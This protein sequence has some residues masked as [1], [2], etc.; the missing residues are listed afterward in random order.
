MISQKAWLN[1][2][3]NDYMIKIALHSVDPFARDMFIYP[4]VA[5][6]RQFISLVD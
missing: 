5:N 3:L 6:Q 4:N 1:I 2:R